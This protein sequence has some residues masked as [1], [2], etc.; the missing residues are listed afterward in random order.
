MNSLFYNIKQGFVQ[1]FR[2]RGMSLASIFSIVSMLLI[3]GLFFVITVNINLFTEV[4]KQDYDQVEVFLL[5]ETTETDARQL[6]A[7][8]EKQD[9]VSGAEYRSKDEALEI[10]KQRWGESGYLLDSLGNNPLPASILIS[11]DSLD[12]AGAVARFAGNLDGVDDIQYYQET[13]DK[14]TKITRFLQ[15]GALVI[16]IFLVVVSVVV[17]SNTVKLT[18]FARAKEIRIM[19]YVGATNWFIRGPFLAE[20]IIIGVLAAL[21]ST[22][23]IAIIYSKIIE[24]IGMQ[25]MAIVSS[26]LISASYMTVNMVIIFVALGASI[27]AWG[28]IISMRRFLDT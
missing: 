19:K 24:S 26:P 21:I 23:L 20:G 14:L 18:V 15:I 2:N 3:L 8:I 10:L 6:I 28:S 4:V 27:G 13:V 1:I 9:G 12:N 5:D 16:M 11:V 7:E 22:G 25:V 17:V